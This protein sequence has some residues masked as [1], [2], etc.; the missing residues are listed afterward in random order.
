[1]TTI[2]TQT[3]SDITDLYR[4][5][6][7][8]QEECASAAVMDGLMAQIEDRDKKIESLEATIKKYED[9]CR[10]VS[11]WDGWSAHHLDAIGGPADLKI[12]IEVQMK[13]IDGLTEEKDELENE[14]YNY[15][16]RIE[17]LE[18]ERD[19]LEEDKEIL[20]EKVEGL[21]EKVS[22]MDFKD[23]RD[24]REEEVMKGMRAL[25][26]MMSDE[27]QEWA[28]E[29]A[30]LLE[31]MGPAQEV[32]KILRE[33]KEVNQRNL[34]K[35]MKANHSLKAEIDTLTKT[36]VMGVKK[37]EIFD[38]LDKKM[39]A[40]L[41]KA[42]RRADIAKSV[43]DGLAAEVFALSDKVKALQKDLSECVDCVD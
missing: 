32:I 16:Q 20:K 9:V 33:E 12:K 39:A 10:S 18:E 1:M 23:Y 35:V 7:V 36:D 3:S 42:E 6:D 41:M 8:A 26:K 34:A 14:N 17:E 2:A 27:R 29:K 13:L 11:E 22:R 40:D 21:E 24:K 15:E 30:E 4:F 25:E 28:T 5:R 38:H 37:K 31:S 19:D 43:A